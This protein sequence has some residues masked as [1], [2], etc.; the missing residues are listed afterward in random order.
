MI[1]LNL[2]CGKL[3]LENHINVDIDQDNEPDLVADVTQPLPF[4][5]GS[6]DEIRAW[7]LLEHIFPGRDPLTTFKA[8]MTDWYRVLCKN[9]M[10]VFAVP[11]FDGCITRYYNEVIVGGNR[12]MERHYK[13]P[14]YGLQTTPHQIH[15]YGFTEPFITDMLSMFGTVQIDKAPEGEMPAFIVRAWK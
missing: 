4:E 14:I 1:K 7:H 6:A 12:E 15:Y 8:I 13:L 11:D 10:L 2:G 9:G 3:Y 5:D